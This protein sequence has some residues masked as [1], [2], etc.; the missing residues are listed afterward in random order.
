MTEKHQALIVEDDPAIVEDLAL[1][2]EALGCGHRAVDNRQHALLEL[3]RETFCFV[4]LDLQ[5]K[6]EP[7]SIKGHAEV[8]HSLLREIR[9]LY[10]DHASGCH[11]LPILVVSGYAREAD[12]AVEVMKDGADDVIQK[13]LNDNKRISQSIRQSLEK[14]G[15]SEHA[16][17]VKYRGSGLSAN[18][19]TLVL[20]IPGERTVRRT[21]VV[22]G[23]RHADLTDRSF[24]VL[25]QLLIAKLK[26]GRVHKEDLGAT[27]DQGFKGV[28]VL[29]EELKPAMPEGR[30]IFVNLYYG[31]YRLGDGIELGVVDFD[32]LIT[33][34]N[35]KICTLLRELKKLISVG[36]SKI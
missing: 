24:G 1:I 31:W 10:P 22:I 9:R 2:L 21:R 27:A 12:D 26:D 13:P 28:S 7:D 32:A 3:E 34:K 25:L 6:S 5:I 19:D 16:A 14:S 30:R 23:G 8:G 17:C 18:G 20:N 4:L 35:E 15:R 33:A 36:G 11:Q 29:A